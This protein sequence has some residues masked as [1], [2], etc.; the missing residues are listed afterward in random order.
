[1]LLSKISVTLFRDISF[2]LEFGYTT[3]ADVD[4]ESRS[5]IGID[6]VVSQITYI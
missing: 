2:P 6:G 1:M 4:N 3:Q 5:I